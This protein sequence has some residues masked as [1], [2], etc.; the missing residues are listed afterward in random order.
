MA[1]HPRSRGVYSFTG[2]AIVTGFGSSPL[3]RGLLETYANPEDLVGIIPA[4]AGFT[5]RGTR[6]RRRERDHP[7]SRGVYDDSEDDGSIDAGSSPPARGLLFRIAE[8]TPFEG[9]IPARAGF[10]PPRPIIQTCPSGSS[11]LAR[12]LHAAPDP[13]HA[14][15]RIIPARAGFTCHGTCPTRS[16]RDHPR[17]RGVYHWPAAIAASRTGSSPLARGLRGRASR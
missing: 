7:R 13:G 3:A 8:K 10:T 17:S 2:T 14:F 11:P 16:R 5:H 6:R 12:G 9:I 4:R 15:R 1:D